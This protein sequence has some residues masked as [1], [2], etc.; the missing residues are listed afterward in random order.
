LKFPITESFQLQNRRRRNPTK[1]GGGVE[2]GTGI[3]GKEGWEEEG[4][5]GFFRELD[6]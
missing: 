1:T 6:E 3:I 5:S 2:K 4:L